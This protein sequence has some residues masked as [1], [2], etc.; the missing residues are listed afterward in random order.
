MPDRETM[1]ADMAGVGLCGTELGPPGFL[2][3][4]PRT[5]RA[6]L[7]RHGLQ[8]VGAFVPLVL[9]EPNPRQ[10]LDAARAAVDLLLRAG[11]DVLVGAAVQDV[12]WSDPQPLDDAGWN[13]LATNAAAVAELCAEHRL[14][15]CVH[16]HV[17]TVLLEAADIERALRQTGPEVHWCLDTGH[18][19]IGGTDPAKFASEHGARVNHVHLKDVNAA[20]AAEVREG[21]TTL[22]DATRRGLFTPLGD[23]AADLHAVLRALQDHGYDGWLVLEQDRT[24]PVDEPTGSPSRD[25][26]RSI[27]FL[28]EVTA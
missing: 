24:S 18:L 26:E 21:R 23:G 9:Q 5:L 13:H 12:Q 3:D 27:R 14:R 25:A 4:S 6:T 17:G 22:L 7:D 10:A 20:I 28:Q 11:G 15:F 19:A 2:A 8:F 16:P 1:L